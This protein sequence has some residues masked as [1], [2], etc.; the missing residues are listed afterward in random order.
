V[1]KWIRRIH[2][3][4]RSGQWKTKPEGLL[5]IGVEDEAADVGGVAESVKEGESNE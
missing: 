2:E 4:R 5:K 3:R 1:L